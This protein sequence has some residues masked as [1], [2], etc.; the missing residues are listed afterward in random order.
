VLQLAK[1]VDATAPSYAQSLH[2][3]SRG[4]D[5][6]WPCKKRSKAVSIEFATLCSQKNSQSC[7]NNHLRDAVHNGPAAHHRLIAP[8]M[9][10]LL[11]TSTNRVRISG[12]SWARDGQGAAL[13]TV[14]SVSRHT[15]A[16]LQARLLRETPRFFPC[17]GLKAGRSADGRVDCRADC[18]PAD[19]R[20]A[21]GRAGVRTGGRASGRTDGRA[22]GRTNGRVEG[23]VS[24]AGPAGCKPAREDWRARI[25]GCTAAASPDALHLF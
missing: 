9:H 25:F 4:G 1:S 15:P 14:W 5:G 18:R 13:R 16:R 3:H 17:R 24:W 20:V 8:P 21:D 6:E 11:Q 23:S 12:R 7:L 22:G 19:G 2:T 10:T